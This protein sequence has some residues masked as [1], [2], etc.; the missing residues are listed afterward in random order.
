MDEILII[1]MICIM[2]MFYAMIYR[3]HMLVSSLSHKIKIDDKL[4]ENYKDL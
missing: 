2:T 4:I 1:M 3:Y